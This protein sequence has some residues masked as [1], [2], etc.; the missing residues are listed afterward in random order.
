MKTRYLMVQGTG[1]HVGKSVL[2]AALCRIFSNRGL[3]VAPFKAQNMALNSAVTADGLEVGRS[4]AVQAQAARV[5]LRVEMNPILLKPK[6]DTIAQ[7]MLMGK[8]YADV[9]AF[10]QFRD[11]RSLKAAKLDAI[12]YSLEVLSREYDLIIIEGA[13]SPAEVN[14]REFDVVNMAVARLVNA[15][16]LL[17]ADIDLGGA[18]AALMGTW[19]LL[20][21]EERRLVRGF[22]FN[23]FHGD[24]RLLD[25]ALT[26]LHERTGCPVVGV[27]PYDH[28]LH[29]MEEDAL[30]SNAM[31]LGDPEIEI[32]VVA[33]RHLSNF[34]DLDPLAIEPGMM[35]RYVR[36]TAQLGRPDAVILP[37][38]KNTIDDL[39]AHLKSGLASRLQALAR[40]GAPI[41]GICGGY[42]ML[43]KVLL[44]PDRL[45][46]AH[47]D[48]EGLG[49]LPVQTLFRPGKVTR[50]T[51]VRPVGRP[52]FLTDSQQVITGYEIRCGETLP[53]GSTTD[54]AFV[55]MQGGEEGAVSENGL[56]VGTSLH[57]LFEHDGFRRQF[58]NALRARK[59]LASLPLPLACFADIQDQALERW[60]QH[61][62]RHLDMA[63]LDTILN[64][65]TAAHAAG[66]EAVLQRD[67]RHPHEVSPTPPG[68]QAV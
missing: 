15:P 35:I 34:T 62:A 20:E 2:V 4:T 7:M 3:R 12:R 22:L 51:A 25:P 13:G 29:L 8:P 49:L 46:S 38:T 64:G 11:G 23:K 45:E 39:V 27:I 55:R 61:V 14:L 44:D 37:G 26:F 59:G 33:H 24:R 56:V 17:M 53:L 10:D 18:I 1:S 30:R 57:G 41:I 43:G 31:G 66:H 58:V 65:Q 63:G 6:A 50:Q 47:G 28:E 52:P 36:T 68:S 19:V 48:L 21:A 5:D 60:A 40:T 67:A 16:V 42:Q 54:H 32:A 9:S